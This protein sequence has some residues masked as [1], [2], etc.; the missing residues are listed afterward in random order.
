MDEY[1][2]QPALQ[3]IGGG[4]GTAL[5]GG[6]VPSEL[7]AGAEQLGGELDRIGDELVSLASTEQGGGAIFNF[8][9]GTAEIFSKYRQS[10]G[11][12][13][14]AQGCSLP[15]GSKWLPE[16]GKKI[17]SAFQQ[18]G[19]ALPEFL[20]PEGGAQSLEI[21]DDLA[22]QAG[23]ALKVPGGIEVSD[24]SIDAL[25]QKVNDYISNLNGYF[26]DF[27]RKAGV[28][29]LEKSIDNS[30][31][32]I[33]FPGFPLIKISPYAPAPIISGIL[34]VSRLMIALSPADLPFLRKLVSLL[35]G[36]L[37]VA[38]GEWKNGIFS[39]LGLFSQARMMTGI[40]F[41]F[42]NNL[43]SFISP[44]I[45][46]EWKFNT[47][48]M[49]KSFFVGILL[50]L[51][52]TFA[53]KLLRAGVG[54][55]MDKI[56]ELIEK[57]NA[58]IDRIEA[59]TEAK[60]I[61]AEQGY[62]IKFQRIPQDRMPDF[63]NMQ[64]LQA[65]LQIPEIVCSKDVREAVKAFENNPLI[66]F[67]LELMNIPTTDEAFARRCKGVSQDVNEAL[68]NRLMPIVTPLTDA[69]GAED[70]RERLAE[71]EKRVE[72][73]SKYA[74]AAKCTVKNCKEHGKGDMSEKH[75]EEEDPTGP[76]AA[77]ASAS[78][79]ASAQV[80]TLVELEHSNTA[81]NPTTSASSE[82]FSKSN[83]ARADFKPVRVSELRP[84]QDGGTRSSR[85]RFAARRHTRSRRLRFNRDTN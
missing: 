52:G 80:S 79:P 42:V 68:V 23:G 38:R 53:P 45:F 26:M 85:L 54:D 44:Q 33:P 73:L 9:Q 47:F 1:Y 35:A 15:D 50:W 32:G 48:A 14:W 62:K 34:E 71:S 78:A 20:Q 28:L 39:F 16:D 27:S 76:V 30:I 7:E 21:P 3:F 58:E 29:K 56:T 22:E 36:L 65:V 31:G 84:R 67:A 24:I 2:D 11:A 17:E 59:E 51:F 63:S 8:L 64:A 72:I 43:L 83:S 81:S 75:E 66:R 10:G 5:G 13:G 37:D 49:A 12:A 40:M 25:F 74:S 60:G 41:K 57:F 77:P 61:G 46:D 82:Q 4:Y 55:Q 18:F 70:M 69:Q 6:E 19:G